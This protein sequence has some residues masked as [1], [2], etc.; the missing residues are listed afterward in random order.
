MADVRINGPVELVTYPGKRRDKIMKKFI[1]N[2]N[3]IGHMIREKNTHINITNDI[4]SGVHLPIYK[5]IHLQE[6]TCRV[7]DGEGVV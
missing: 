7:I 6:V 5:Y 3:S 1:L 4:A 2:I